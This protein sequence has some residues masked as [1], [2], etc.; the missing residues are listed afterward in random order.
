VF[1]CRLPSAGTAPA[2]RA[3]DRHPVAHL[4]NVALVMP[5]REREFKLTDISLTGC[6]IAIAPGEAKT[7]FPLGRPLGDVHIQVGAKAKVE[8]ESLTPRSYYPNA[9]GCAFA[10][11]PEGNSR[12]YLERTIETLDRG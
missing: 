9:V 7:I 4:T 10:V 5:K 1:V 6:R 3:A 12:V 11:K 2:K 8:L